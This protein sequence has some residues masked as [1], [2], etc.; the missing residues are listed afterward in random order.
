[1][2][3]SYFCLV[4]HSHIPFVRGAGA[5][6][7]GEETLF[8]VIAESYIPLLNALYDLVEEGHSPRITIGFTPILLEQLADPQLIRRFQKYLRDKKKVAEKD[9]RRFRNG[10]QEQFQAL[11]EFYSQWYAGLLDSFR[12]RFSGDLLSGFRHLQDEGHIEILTSASTHGYL[13]LLER[14]SSI[15]GQLKVGV[16]TYRRH[17]R[18]PPQGIWL[19]ECG[20]R[21]PYLKDGVIKPGV[22]DFLNELGLGYFFTDTHALRGGPLLGKAAG[23]IIGPYASVPKRILL[24]R[25][26]ERVSPATT[27]RP[28]FVED[29]AMAVLAR[30]ERTGLQV[31]SESMG[32]PGDADYREFHR[33]AS[34]SGLQYWRITAANT[35]LG[36]KELYNPQWAAHRVREH[37]QHFAGVIAAELAGYAS[38][39]GEPGI[40]VAAYD[41]E[42]FGHWW[43]EGMDFLKELIRRLHQHPE[44]ELTTA[45]AYLERYPPQEAISLPESSWG[46]GGGH[47]TWLNPQTEWMW[48]L[49][50]RAEQWMEELVAAYPVARGRLRQTLEQVARELLLLQAS[51]WPFL[52]STGQAQEFA[53][54]RFQ[55]HL[56]RF[57]HLATIAQKGRVDREDSQYLKQ[58]VEGDN[59]F[60]EIDYRVFAARESS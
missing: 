55:K 56:A 49:I 28:Y 43:F 26:P 10:G 59:P 18:R 57:H 60:P 21:P 13:P 16:E 45:A 53:A 46:Q 38:E 11:A 44:V 15:Y 25:Q 47:D 40:V 17:F 12:H 14:D 37:A 58:V 42:L 8:Q 22:A 23:D 48:P 35:E 36:Q 6:P 31:W 30:N 50:H 33:Q 29:T 20:Y 3:R 5:W 19:P 32:Y 9:A 27:F 1:M 39:D 2:A 41:T 7:F 24:E 52:V 34:T 51:D 4:L 54:A